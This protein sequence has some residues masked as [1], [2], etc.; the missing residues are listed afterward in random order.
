MKDANN[1]LLFAAKYRQSGMGRVKADFQDL[2]RWQ[3][4]VD[5]LDLAAVKHD[6]LDRSVTQI[7]SAQ[8]AIAVLLF[9]D[10]FRMTKL[11]GARDFL[12]HRHDPA[13]RVDP[14]AKQQQNAAHDA[15][16]AA[17]DR[18]QKE[19]QPANRAGHA[20]RRTFG[21][22]DG[23]GLW[24]NFGKN[25]HQNSH[26]QGRKRHATFAQGPREHCGGKRS[27]KDIDQIVPKKDRSDQTFAVLG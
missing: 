16:Y 22:R 23:I 21:I 3:I 7:K 14:D 9:N 15:A 24:Q 26:D 5:H 27:R 13:V 6:F 17:H 19:Y 10:P 20:R 25:Q 12:A 11:Q 1:I 2:L 4:S 18:I 8:D